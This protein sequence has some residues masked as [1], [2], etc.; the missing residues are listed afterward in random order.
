MVEQL[1][2]DAR[3]QATYGAAHLGLVQD[4]L[5]AKNRFTALP[6]MECLEHRLMQPQVPEVRLH[7]EH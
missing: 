2:D 4:Q 3:L 1:S 7:Q 6:A 5:Q